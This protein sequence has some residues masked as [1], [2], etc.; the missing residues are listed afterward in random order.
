MN[1]NKFNFNETE[2]DIFKM[3]TGFAF[4]NPLFS[5]DGVLIDIDEQCDKIFI[6]RDLLRCNLH[7]L[8]SIATVD[9]DDDGNVSVTFSDSY[10]VE[11][12]HIGEDSSRTGARELVSRIEAF[13][14][15]SGRDGSSPDCASNGNVTACE[16]DASIEE[17]RRYEELYSRL[18]NK[19]RSEA[20]DYL[21]S[22]AGMSEAEAVK[23]IEEY[24][25]LE[26][27]SEDAGKRSPATDEVK[28][29]NAF[30]ATDMSSEEIL[31]FIKTLKPGELICI[32]Y[33]PL[34]GKI[35]AINCK[36]L[37][38]GV[39][40][41]S[42]QSFF[43]LDEEAG[44]Y[45]SFLEGVMSSLFDYMHL[46]VYDIRRSSETDYNLDRVKRISRINV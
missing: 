38:L 10:K 28:A 29:G 34:F 4:T 32:E 12:F 31:D 46:H 30:P 11:R 7:S 23:Y 39:E 36:Y 27:G 16:S 44:D 45:E 3:Q 5:D 8:S 21:V 37:K 2:L 43:F 40:V 41:G 35:R 14:G 33:N 6:G 1:G 24:P 42:R 15:D 20:V 22:E 17:D 13:T 9:S 19:G 25:W 26:P 18:L